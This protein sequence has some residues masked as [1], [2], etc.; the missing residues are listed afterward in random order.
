L[1]RPD[2]KREW[3]WS[4]DPI[5]LPLAYEEREWN[6]AYMA[7]HLAEYCGSTLHTVHVRARPGGVAATSFVSRLNGLA[8]ALRIRITPH[9]RV[10]GRGAK[11]AEIAGEIVRVASQVGAQAIVMAGHKESFFTELFGRV[12]DRVARTAPCRVVLVESLEP[13][14]ELP[15]RPTRILVPV[16]RRGLDPEPLIVAAAL[17]STSTVP[18]AEITVARFVELPPTT[19]LDALESLEVVRMLEREFSVEVGDAIMRLG[20]VFNPKILPVR[21]YASDIR[22]YVK[23]NGVELMILGGGGRPGR[24]R[25]LLRPEE[26]AIVRSSPC[27]VVVVFPPPTSRR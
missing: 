27:P 21:E 26:M 15:S 1:S 12:S 6:A 2:K 9:E 14:R 8:A 23:E 25:A 5:V 11:R 22:A 10:L 3:A 20:R 19:P 7:L 24:L 17:T 4:D 13:P 18:G 16:I